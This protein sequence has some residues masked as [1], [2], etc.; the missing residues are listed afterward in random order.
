M[1]DVFHR[2]HLAHVGAAARVADHRGAAAD[3]G[4]RLVARHLQALH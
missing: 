3:E 4:N 2:E 1:L